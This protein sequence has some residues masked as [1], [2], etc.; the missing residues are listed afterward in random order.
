[1]AHLALSKVA[2]ILSLW[3]GVVAT[4]FAL[5]HVVPTDPA[6]TI[7]GANASEA[8]V[9]S[10]RHEMGLDRPLPVQFASYL[11]KVLALEFGRSYVDGRP[12]GK[13]VKRKLAVTSALA[14]LSVAVI[15]LYVA[16]VI[17]L[18]WRQS[19]PRV[20]ALLNFLCISSPTLFTSVVVAI[21]V[22]VYFPYNRFSG[23]LQVPG[24]WLFLV[25]P[26]VVL[27]L[28]PMGILAGVARNQISLVRDADYVRA[29]CARGL[30]EGTILRTYV[31]RNSLMPLLATFGHQLPL[32]L[33]STFIVEIVFSVPGIGALLLKSVLERDLPMIEGIVVVTSL[34]TVLVSLLLEV[35]YPFIDPRVRRV[36]AT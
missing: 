10:L 34:F 11:S 1:M 32:L 20:R 30:A 9:A 13:E 6:R 7:L 36:H 23:S 14:S 15:A 21:A 12:V 22:V 24:D 5:F 27:A 2:Y 8:Q 33:T 18:E 35:L 19:A 17:I 26:A 29:A 28:Y 4:S 25:P 3:L 16:A 31:L